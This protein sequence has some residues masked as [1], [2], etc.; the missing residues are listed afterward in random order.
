MAATATVPGADAIDI[1]TIGLIVLIVLIVLI[2]WRLCAPLA[3]C[4][5]AIATKIHHADRPIGTSARFASAAGT[6]RI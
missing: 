5:S 4:R 6:I 3:R 2:P 1:A